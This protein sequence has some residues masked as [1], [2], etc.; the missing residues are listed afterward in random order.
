MLC[1]KMRFHIRFINNSKKKKTKKKTT[2]KRNET[3]T[4]HLL[5]HDKEKLH[6]IFQWNCINLDEL[7]IWNNLVPQNAE[8]I[9]FYSLA[10]TI[11]RKSPFILKAINLLTICYDNTWKSPNIS[12]FAKNG[13]TCF[14]SIR[15]NG[16]NDN[17]QGNGFMVT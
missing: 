12:S 16:N 7:S 2:E 13:L 3:F 17:N 9:P 4:A 10:Y 11:Q 5:Y 8:M 1:V 14:F 15:N 6:E